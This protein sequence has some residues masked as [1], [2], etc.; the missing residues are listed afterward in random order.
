M[1]R[2]GETSARKAKFDW[3]NQKTRKIEARRPQIIRRSSQKTL[4]NAA[5]G[6]AHQPQNQ[7]FRASAQ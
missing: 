1:W 2:R 5:S 6:L 3:I 7:V 4:P